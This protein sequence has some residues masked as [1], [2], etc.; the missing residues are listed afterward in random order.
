MQQ[1]TGVSVADVVELQLEQTAV[2]TGDAF[3]QTSAA[4][5]TTQQTYSISSVP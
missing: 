1:H 5:I 3:Q 4:L 2:I